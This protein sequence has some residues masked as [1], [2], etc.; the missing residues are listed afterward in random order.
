M[1]ELEADF[2]KTGGGPMAGKASQSKTGDDGD[3]IQ[4]KRKKLGQGVSMKNL[5]GAHLKVEFSRKTATS[6]RVAGRL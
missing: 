5:K 3:A 1:A 4:A 6:L 2:L